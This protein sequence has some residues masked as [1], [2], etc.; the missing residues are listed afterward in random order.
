M[1]DIAALKASPALDR[2]TLDLAQHLLT[3]S[4]LGTDDIADLLSISLSATDYIGHAYGP[5][6]REAEDNFARLDRLLAAFLTTLDEQFGREQTLIVLS[7]D[8][9]ICETP[10]TLA[11]LGL[12]ARRLLEAEIEKAARGALTQLY[13]TDVFLLGVKTP[14]VYLNRQK[15]RDAGQDLQLMRHGLAAGLRELPGVREAFALEEPADG[16]PLGLQV[17]ASTRRGRSGDVYVVA[18]P[19]VQ[20]SQDANLTA[21]HGSPWAYDAH[22]PIILAGYVVPHGVARRSVDVRSLAGTVAAIVGVSPPA[23]AIRELLVEALAQH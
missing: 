18:E 10:E 15:I 20:L 17:Q 16:T 11:A 9:G 7:S 1:D 21:T 22:V 13:G 2:A 8:H 6:S 23:G 4:A 19:Y 3:T 12:P 5:E 14:S